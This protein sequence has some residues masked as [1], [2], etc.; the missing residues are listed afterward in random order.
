MKSYVLFGNTSDL[1][2]FYDSYRAVTREVKNGNWYPEVNMFTGQLTWPVF[3]AL[4]G[5]LVAPFPACVVL[6]LLFHRTAT[7]RLLSRP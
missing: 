1:L 5:L 2:L 4:Q 3:T 6:G 7:N